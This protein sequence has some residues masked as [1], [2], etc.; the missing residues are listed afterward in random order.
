MSTPT[1]PVNV[2]VELVLAG[3]IS[4]SEAAR[5]AGLSQGTMSRRVTAHPGYAKAKAGG[6]I[7]DRPG[8]GGPVDV[9][10]LRS[11]PAVVAVAEG[12]MSL[13]KAVEAYPD[14]APNPVTL[15]RWVSKAFPNYAADPERG[16]RRRTTEEM[17]APDIAVLAD[18]I[19]AK[20]KAL[21]VD[22][23][24]LAKWVAQRVTA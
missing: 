18:A 7:G 9:D 23:A 13:R 10:A 24:K 4:V 8:A 5:R 3:E 21:N 2:A 11:N 16:G 12:R 14:A 15:G 1:T 6:L 22:P 17:L 19:L 20:A